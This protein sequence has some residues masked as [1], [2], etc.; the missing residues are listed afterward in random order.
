MGEGTTPMVIPSKFDDFRF[1]F[2]SADAPSLRVF[3]LVAGALPVA[4]RKL[5]DR[6]PGQRS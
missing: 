2:R 1:R 6:S 5:P 4:L 3:S